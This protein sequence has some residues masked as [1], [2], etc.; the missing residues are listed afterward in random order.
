MEI[1]EIRVP[2]RN[3]TEQHIPHLEQADPDRRLWGTPSATQ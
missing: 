1:A 3:K 2:S